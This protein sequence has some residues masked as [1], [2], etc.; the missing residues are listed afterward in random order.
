MVVDV[1]T[2]PSFIAGSPRV[3]LD[4]RQLTSYGGS[5]DVS[6]DGERFLFS[7]NLTTASM[8]LVVILNWTEELKRLVPAR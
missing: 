5:Y 2:E 4:A 6:P 8:S 1:R 7:D 3:L